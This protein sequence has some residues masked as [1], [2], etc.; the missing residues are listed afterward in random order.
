MV[1]GS[2]S[3]QS[4]AEA[5]DSNGNLF[6]GLVDSTSIACWDSDVPYDERSF[7]TIARD[8]DTLQFASGVKV[9]PNRL[10]DEELWVLTNR[11]QKFIL[12]T[13]KWTEVNFRIQVGSISNILRGRKCRNF[14]PLNVKYPVVDRYPHPNLLG[15]RS[16][17][18]SPNYDFGVSPYRVPPS[19]AVSPSFGGPP[20]YGVSPSYNRFGVSPNYNFLQYF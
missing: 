5:I 10:K 2:R 18:A 1:S 20:S 13:M 3:S 11:L 16:F 17:G 6:F 7:L 12:N 4:A 8:P 15:V 9:I 14:D 19:Y